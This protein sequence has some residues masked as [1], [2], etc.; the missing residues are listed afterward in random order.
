MFSEIGRTYIAGLFSPTSF[1]GMTLI[2]GLILLLKGKMKY[3]KV[4]LSI[5]V[6]S[7]VIMTMA[8][9]KYV[10]Y[11]Q[12]EHAEINKPIDFEFVVVLGGKI[13]PNEA[14]P[15]SSQLTPSLL[16]RLAYAIAIVKGKPGSKLVLTGN[17]AG[18]KSEAELMFAFARQMG[19]EPE[20]I[21]LE[22]ESMNTDDHPKYLK[23]LLTG[24]QFAIVTSAY[25][26]DRALRSFK[27]QGLIGHPYPTDY[28][29]KN[30]LSAASFIMRGENLSSLDRIFTEIYSSLWTRIKSIF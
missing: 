16:S 9:L 28:Q 3:S 19:V 8:P 4:V 21:I 25:H 5:G 30:S 1:I 11:S 29:N 15:L 18:E 12:F 17:G 14:H 23:S 24:K 6:I 2:I 22:K 10:L 13:F 26:M 20:R 27:A 7:F